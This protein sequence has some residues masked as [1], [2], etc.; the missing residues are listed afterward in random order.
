MITARQTPKKLALFSAT[1]SV[2]LLT[3]GCSSNIPLISSKPAKA[4]ATFLPAAP[5]PV[6]QGDAT[7]NSPAF[8]DTVDRIPSP[9]PIKVPVIN[10]FGELDGQ[11]S[12]SQPQSADF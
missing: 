2:V 12:Q 7:A 1:F 6:A 5:P 3:A 10:M 8:V 4:K 11:I 9:E